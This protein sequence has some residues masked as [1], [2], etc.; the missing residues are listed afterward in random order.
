MEPQ[1]INCKRTSKINN[2]TGHD[3]IFIMAAEQ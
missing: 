1:E 3:Q 2:E